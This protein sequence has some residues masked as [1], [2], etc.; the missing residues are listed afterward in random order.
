[1][2]EIFESDLSRSP[3]WSDVAASSHPGPAARPAATRLVIASSVRLVREG[4]AASLYGRHGIA[5]VGAVTLDTQ[6]IDR[7][8]AVE[9]HVVLVDLSHANATATARLLRIAAPEAKLVAF[10][11]DEIDADVFACA[12]AGFSGYIPRESSAD[13]LYRA[14][15]DVMDGRMHC[16]PHIA[17]AMFRR[18]ADLLH[19][20]DL[21]ASLPS[22]TSR[23]RE[24]L[25]LAEAG[26]S[27]KEIARD[28]TIS[29][30][31]VK[32]HMHN[33]LLKLQVTRRG[34]AVARLRTCRGG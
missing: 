28:L 17:G 22:L 10:A 29:C 24:I 4:L 9:P 3:S 19:A 12:A 8:A 11:L 1:M 7:I 15:V 32:N 30:A 6:S 25:A 14:V 31:T 26:Y 33:I 5:V 2:V 21:Q 34:Q 23:E 27:N 18:L 16:A 20:T 13:E